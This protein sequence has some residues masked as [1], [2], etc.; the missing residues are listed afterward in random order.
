[1]CLQ[2]SG[3]QLIN[4]G[5]TLLRDDQSINQTEGYRQWNVRDVPEDWAID[6]IWGQEEKEK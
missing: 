1:M 2:D 3:N 4:D 5:N 6:Q